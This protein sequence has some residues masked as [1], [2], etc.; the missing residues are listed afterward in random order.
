MGDRG[1]KIWEVEGRNG[2]VGMGGGAGGM[3]GRQDDC[4]TFT[5]GAN[6]ETVLF[7][8][9]ASYYFYHLYKQ[10]MIDGHSSVHLRCGNEIRRD[11]ALRAPQAA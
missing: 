3:G 4:P 8:V 9:R 7:Q 6:K 1:R 10:I 5:P 2:G 11:P